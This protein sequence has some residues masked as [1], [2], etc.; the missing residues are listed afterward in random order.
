[1]MIVINCATTL[2][3]LF[4]LSLTFA[5]STAFGH[6][7]I[8]PG[9]RQE[10]QPEGEESKR[11]KRKKAQPRNADQPAETAAPAPDTEAQTTPAKPNKPRRQKPPKVSRRPAEPA[12]TPSLSPPVELSTTPSPEPTVVAMAT[13]SLTA[14]STS[15]SKPAS[16]DS[17]LS[18]PVVLGLFALTLI[19]LIVTVLMLMKQLRGASRPGV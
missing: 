3:V 8:S 9:A 14:S 6:E 16:G 12:P 19:A 13:P 2:L 1:M 4:A 11:G 10:V 7:T 5:T 17:I 15:A 18:L